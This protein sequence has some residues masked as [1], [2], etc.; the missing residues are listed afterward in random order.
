M[1]AVAVIS[2]DSGGGL[3]VW[4]EA[5]IARYVSFTSCNYPFKDRQAAFVQLHAAARA[6]SEDVLQV[7]L[8]NSKSSPH[9]SDSN[10]RGTGRFSG[11]HTPSCL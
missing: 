3:C 6:A 7:V 4:V 1:L 2:A 5:H 11:L 10:N 8:L 9:D